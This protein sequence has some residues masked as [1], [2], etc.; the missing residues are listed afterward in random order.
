MDQ[1]KEGDTVCLNDSGTAIVPW[2][3]D[4]LQNLLMLTEAYNCNCLMR[5]QPPQKRAPEL[6]QQTGNI[7]DLL[8]GKHVPY[9]CIT[10]G[11]PTPLKDNF[12]RLLYRC[13]KEY[14]ESVVNILTNGKTF[15]D[16]MFVRDA[17]HVTS[18]NTLS[19]VSPCPEIDQ[20]HDG[21]AGKEGSFD[22]TQPGIYN[23]A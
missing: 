15:S 4:S 1:V 23:L 9:I 2:E 5:S 11:E 21:L 20:I 12:I 10:G 8:H 17:A 7:L 16:M 22:R 13:A 19:C 14:P 3:K 6:L 18:A